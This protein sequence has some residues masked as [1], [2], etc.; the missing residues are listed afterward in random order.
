MRRATIGAAAALLLAACSSG[1]PGVPGGISGSPSPST[2]SSVQATVNYVD[3]NAQRIDVNVYDVSQL[4]TSSSGQSVYYD[5]HTQVM[6]QGQNYRPADL[7]RG[8]QVAVQG[9]NN[10]SQYLADMITVTRN[11]TTAR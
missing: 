10:N 5:S 3:T 6:Y 11:G 9:H 8:D 4:K 2:P 7:E 1:G